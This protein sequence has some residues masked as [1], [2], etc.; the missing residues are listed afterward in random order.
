MVAKRE[1]EERIENGSA[2]RNQVVKSGTIYSKQGNETL[3][4]FE[5]FKF[6]LSEKNKELEEV[7]SG[8][9]SQYNLDNLEQRKI[10]LISEH[11]Q[12]DAEQ[13]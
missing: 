6:D 13:K 7:K 8:F 11:D 5:R 4:I 3:N 1:Q 2:H 10:I 12:Y 9:N